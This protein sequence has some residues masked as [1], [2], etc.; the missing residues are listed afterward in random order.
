[1]RTIQFT[2]TTAR[3]ASALLLALATA[4]AAAMPAVP[5]LAQGALTIPS[6]TSIRIRVETPIRSVNTN[7]G[8]PFRAEVV[9]PVVVRGQ[10]V[11]PADTT[12]TGRV[13]GVSQAKTWG[14]PSGVTILIE[15]LTSPTGESVDVDGDLTDLN[16]NLMNT[17]DNLT[18]GSQIAF[19]TTRPL[20]VD[21]SFY[22]IN[23]QGG[24]VFNTPTT[25]TLAQTALR[26]FGFYN[27]PIDG[28]LSPATRTAISQFQREN[29]LQQTGFL[30]RE[31]LA[32][33]GL[34][35]TGGQEVVAV[36]VLSA[37]ARTRGG[38][39]QVKIVA[40]TPSANWQ[41]FENHFRVRDALHI[42]VRGVR[43]LRPSAQVLTTA[44]L[45]VALA[46]NEFEGLNRIVIH[47]AGR[48]V[49]IIANE[50]NGSGQLTLEEASALESQITRMLTDYA[51]A[52][53][54]RYVPFTG[55]VVLGRGNYRENEIELLFAL[56]SLSSTAR[57]Y[58]QVIRTTND[59]Q[60]IEGATDLYIAQ[61]RMMDSAVQRTR[62]PRAAS[63][64]RAWG[65]TYERF[66]E[67]GAD[68]NAVGQR[69]F[70]NR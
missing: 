69:G 50:F 36:N 52:I 31:T 32:R 55:Q 19:R 16:G 44:E 22:M 58:T 41:V 13:V 70:E 46:R 1:M 27:G 12:L 34:I 7:V 6:G 8:A 14:Q 64:A 28:R 51:R 62:S 54:V 25:V 4:F 5:A 59:P 33:M 67:L 30:D 56:N 60:A 45:D 18:A 38:Q 9:S 49:T 37:S 66:V 26:D 40:Q 47:G 42:Y 39:L 21:A 35:G 24:D 48:D 15:S 57:L 20:T 63:V 61:A 68:R 65:A 17:V 2:S 43:P 11:I 53:G 23:D 29:R 10:E 3:R